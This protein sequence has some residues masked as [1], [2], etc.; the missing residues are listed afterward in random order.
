MP[1]FRRTR[2]AAGPTPFLDE[3]RQSAIYRARTTFCSTSTMSPGA[4]TG[5]AAL[6]FLG[7][8]DDR[9][10]FAMNLNVERFLNR[11]FSVGPLLQ[12][13]VTGNLTQIGVSGQVKYWLNL[14]KALKLTAQGGLGF[15]HT[16]VPGSGTSL[17]VPPGVGFRLRAEP[18]R[19]RDGDLRRAS[20]A[21]PA[22]C[23]GSASYA[24]A[25]FGVGA[26]EPQ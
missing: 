11:S 15:M 5:G 3:R 2:L 14:S 10:A 18:E 12:F 4:W 20:P 9:T 6:G 13:G 19:Q 21:R 24:G 8:T 1:L 25:G 7:N 16:D 17:L 23:S 26:G 22:C